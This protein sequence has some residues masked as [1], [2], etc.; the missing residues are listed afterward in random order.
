LT[1]K[2][3]NRNGPIGAQAT[4]DVRINVQFENIKMYKVDYSLA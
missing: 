4:H 1:A 3:E 2:I